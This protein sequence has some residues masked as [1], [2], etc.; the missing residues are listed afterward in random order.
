MDSDCQEW[1]DHNLTQGKDEE[2]K[3]FQEEIDIS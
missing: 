2:V 3:A 1:I